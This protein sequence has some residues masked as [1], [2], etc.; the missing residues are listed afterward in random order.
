MLNHVKC[1]SFT[2]VGQVRST[3]EEK[4]SITTDQVVNSS[5]VLVQKAAFYNPSYTYNRCMR[6]VLG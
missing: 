4:I 5:V 2:L 3:E 1:L 6:S